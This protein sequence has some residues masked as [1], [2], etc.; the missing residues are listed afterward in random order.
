MRS[1]FRRVTRSGIQLRNLFLESWRSCV[2]GPFLLRLAGG[3]S[4]IRCLNSSY[5]FEVCLLCS[6]RHS[7]L[8]CWQFSAISNYQSLQ[9]RWKRESVALASCPVAEK[10]WNS[11]QKIACSSTYDTIETAPSSSSNKQT[12]SRLD[13]SIFSTMIDLSLICS[14]MRF[15]SD[16]ALTL[17]Y[18]RLSFWHTLGDYYSSVCETFHFGDQM[19]WSSMIQRVASILSSFQVCLH[20]SAR[21][22][23][24]PSNLK[25][26][27]WQLWTTPSYLGSILDCLWLIWFWSEILLYYLMVLQFL[28]PILLYRPF[29]YWKDFVKSDYYSSCLKMVS[30]RSLF[31]FSRDFPFC[32]VSQSALAFCLFSAILDYYPSCPYNSPFPLWVWVVH[33]YPNFPCGF[34]FSNLSASL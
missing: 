1:P 27:T 4:S 29:S 22:L 32:L 10:H 21:C 7:I 18:C 30:W 2:S 34:S 25:T 12:N 9:T 13:L 28:M 15:H 20:A 24:C 3:W 11:F 17:L 16:W 6:V 14:H 31:C 23:F 5:L 8:S 19:D 26:P 33:L